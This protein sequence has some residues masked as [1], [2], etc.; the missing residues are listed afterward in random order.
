MARSAMVAG[1]PQPIRTTPSRR[2]VRM[3]IIALQG[4][5]AGG[6]AIRATRM[7]QD[8]RGLGEQSARALRTILNRCEGRG[9]PQLD[10]IL[11][12]RPRVQ[13][14]ENC[15]TSDRGRIAFP[16]MIVD[17]HISTDILQMNSGTA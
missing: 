8:L 11:R 12:L 13:R 3:L 10:R 15:S 2:L 4:A 7:H 6:M 16:C 9:R 17:P 1:D 5:I 14:Q